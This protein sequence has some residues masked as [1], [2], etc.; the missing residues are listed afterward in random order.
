[1][2]GGNRVRLQGLLIDS[3]VYRLKPTYFSEEHVIIN[4]L[5]PLWR[6]MRAGLAPW[7]SFGWC[8]ALAVPKQ[9]DISEY[10][11]NNLCFCIFRDV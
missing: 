5:P 2:E 9:S 6:G 3:F 7:V 1:M 8:I 11:P 10:I 4:P